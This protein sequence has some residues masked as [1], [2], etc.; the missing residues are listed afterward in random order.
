[1]EPKVQK[2]KNETIPTC[3]AAEVDG[4]ALLA[5]ASEAEAVET[6]EIGEF[7]LGMTVVIYRGYKNDQRNR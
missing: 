6:W 1:M 5:P 2:M 4:G 3:W 7:E